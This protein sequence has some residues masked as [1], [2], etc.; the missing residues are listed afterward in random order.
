MA[1][2]KGRWWCE[3]E[4]GEQKAIQHWVTGIKLVLQL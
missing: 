1:Q 4:G 2:R 3:L